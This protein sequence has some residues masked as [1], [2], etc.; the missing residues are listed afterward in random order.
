MIMEKNSKFEAAMEKWKE[1]AYDCA[2]RE[3]EDLLSENPDNPRIRL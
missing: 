2:A 3:F 1:G